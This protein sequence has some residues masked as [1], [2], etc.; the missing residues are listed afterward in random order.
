MPT[1]QDGRRAW[2]H[3]GRRSLPGR[4]GNDLPGLDQEG[5]PDW[6]H[7][8]MVRIAVQQQHTQLTI[9]PLQLLAQRRLDDVLTGGGPAGLQLLGKGDEVAQLA[10]VHAAHPQ[11]RAGEHLTDRECP[12]RVP[13]SPSC[14]LGPD[15]ARRARLR[16]ALLHWRRADR[17]RR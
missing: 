7:L 13:E 1:P 10:E 6:R 12:K 9:Q 17:S 3:V 16:P 2:L 4:C 8:H 14:I 15:R 11:L 5:A